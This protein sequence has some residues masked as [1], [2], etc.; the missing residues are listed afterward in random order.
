LSIGIPKD[1]V[2]QYEVDLKTDK[3]LLVV[4]GTPGAIANAQDILSRTEHSSCTVHGEK[5]FA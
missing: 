5:V 1:S 4:H 3:F 2:L